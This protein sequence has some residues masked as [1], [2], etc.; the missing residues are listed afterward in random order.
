MQ[1]ESVAAARSTATLQG[2]G[3][4]RRF[5][6]FAMEIADVLAGWSWWKFA[7]VSVLILIAGAILDDY[8]VPPVHQKPK[9]TI[10]HGSDS[11]AGSKE[12]GKEVAKDAS[13]DANKDATKDANKDSAKDAK[14][15]A[16]SGGVTME[17]GTSGDYT[18]STPRIRIKI[19]DSGVQIDAA[20]A[21]ELSKVSESL[22]ELAREMHRLK[23]SRDRDVPP[24][25]EDE[26]WAET[27]VEPVFG[28]GMGWREEPFV[29]LAK[30]AVVCML[31]LKVIGT[32]RRREQSAQAVAVSAERD[33]ESARLEQELA[34]A[35]LRQLQ[36]QVEP[37]FLFNTLAALQQL[38]ATDPQRAEAMNR[39][40]ID[41][42]R[43]GL[44]M[45]RQQQGSLADEEVLLTN[46]L[47]LMKVRME[48]RLNW[49]IDIPPELKTMT[50]PSL[51]LQPLVENAI[52]HG[53]EPKA[54]G[55]MILIRAQ[56]LDSAAGVQRLRLVVEDDGVGFD[57]TSGTAPASGQRGGLG[58]DS[59]RS[60]LKLMYG[61]QAAL[62]LMQRAGGG[63]VVQIDMPV[64]REPLSSAPGLPL[65]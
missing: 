64:P 4:G 49:T 33:R 22:L 16:D 5:V 51:L 39:H 6:T 40:L 26:S 56:R 3:R 44:K 59:V 52:R 61:N 30:L 1:P 60:R 19:D 58:L 53:L 12:A 24:D 21:K 17:T 28:A 32:S 57:P 27:L 8:L 35:K 34:E 20:D 23:R 9:V 46:Y 62:S 10:K 7:G 63:T 54:R 55:G 42:L 38:I 11:K 31:I 65:P 45:M 36:T 47:H 48:D 13:K 15:G 43:S 29:G 50:V 37:H 25:D 2:Q 41:W 18:M 14:K